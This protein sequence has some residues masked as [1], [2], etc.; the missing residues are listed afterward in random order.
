[1]TVRSALLSPARNALAEVLGVTRE[2]RLLVVTDPAT[3]EIGDAFAVA[4]SDLGAATETHVLDESARPLTELP[5]AL[6]AAVADR[7]VAVNAF[8]ARTEETP[9]RIE[10]CRLLDA[11]DGLRYGHAPG[12]AESMFRDGPLDID[13]ADMRRYASRMRAAL[14]EAVRIRIVAPAGTDVTIAVPARPFWSDLRARPG[15]GVNLPCGEIYCAP[16][17]VGADGLIVCDGTAS[18]LG[19]APAV[20]RIS[21]ARGRVTNLDC[22][23]AEFLA[24]VEALLDADDQARVI[25][26]LGIG[27]NPGARL[28]G[29]M[30][31]DEKARGTCHIAFGN[32]VDMGGGRNSSRVHHD[33]LIRQPTLSVERTDG[34]TTTV[35]ENGE[36]VG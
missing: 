8:S 17:E 31:E 1:M 12:I 11:H 9:F 18:G 20:L 30:L 4:A 19:P 28:V 25:G 33:F 7:T 27:V 29:N 14:S 3:R 36:L 2:D 13:Y 34:K 16:V 22:Q 21:V 5:A 23:H 24:R 6:V 32:N 26:E 10:L 15:K 35:L